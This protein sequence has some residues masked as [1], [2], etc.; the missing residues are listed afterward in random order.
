MDPLT[1]ALVMG[2]IGLAKSELVDRP[3]EREQRRQAAVIARYSPWTGMT[4]GG[5][6]QANPFAS[7]VEGGITGAMLG[8]S[9]EK[10]S[11]DMAASKA[12]DAAEVSL[13]GKTGPFQS[14]EQYPL[15]LAPMPQLE[16][17]VAGPAQY[18][19]SAGQSLALQ[20]MG[21]P[22]LPMQMGP[23]PA[24]QQLASR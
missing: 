22:W 2:G 10:H 1:T 6:Q 18:S 4:P 23:Q 15:A 13:A 17:P 11:A 9:M 21:S 8:Q 5:I 19:P 24:R 7:A 3:R 14:A 20:P 12:K 16:Q